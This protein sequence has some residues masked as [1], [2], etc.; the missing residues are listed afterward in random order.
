MNAIT[1]TQVSGV[2]PSRESQPLAGVR[3][4]VM[5]SGHDVSDP[6][7]YIKQARS[8]RRLGARVAIAGAVYKTAPTDV[9]I[10]PVSKPGSRVIRFSFQPWKCLW[11][12][13]RE[14]CDIIHVHDAEMLMVLPIAK[15]RWP[16]AKFVYDVHEDFANLMLIRGWLPN[17]I[18][19][20]IKFGVDLVEKSLARLADGIVGVTP[21]L[22]GRFP[23]RNKTT[24]FNYTSRHFFEA[25]A[26][27][28]RPPR[29]REFDVVHLG[30]LNPK[31]GAFLCEA[32]TE[33]HRRR[34]QTRSLIV[35]ILTPEIQE[36]LTTKLPR[37][38]TVLGRTDHERLPG[39]LGNAR[40]GVDVHPWQQP[41]LQV[42]IPVKVC[43]Y[44][45]AGCAV[46]CSSMPVLDQVMKEA[47]V[48]SDIRTIAGGTPGEYA[49]AI[50]QV[51]THIEAGE[52]PGARLRIAAAAQMTWENEA[53][54]IA[55]LY[56]KMLGPAER[57][58]RTMHTMEAAQL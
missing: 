16:G 30:T 36:L 20:A 29:Y 39:L 51:L 55:E 47:G 24:A 48:A 41:H 52:D 44:M 42:A 27:V 54:K 45:A 5:T 19:P 32:L 43:E 2:E 17:W 53:D 6:R 23:N 50:L 18:R 4:L 38:C 28:A 57:R 25:C 58:S 49:E 14:Q 26:T 10:L 13:R 40:I 11:R 22:T 33:L 12:A 15:L 31:R 56:L 9:V 37:N 7:I 21:P 3:L 35:G 8:L 1:S 46:V 34:P